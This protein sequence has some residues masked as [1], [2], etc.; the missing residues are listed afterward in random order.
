MTK[1]LIFWICIGY[2][3][4]NFHMASLFNVTKLQRQL[5][6]REVSEMAYGKELIL[7]LYNCD[8]SKFNRESI[9]EWLKELCV[10]INMSRAD[11]H[12]HY[13]DYVGYE[14]GA[15]E[16]MLAPKHLCGTSG[17]QFITTSNITIHTLDKAKE[18]YINIFSCRN[19]S[20]F[21]AARFTQDWFSAAR[22]RDRTIDR[23]EN[24]QCKC[25]TLPETDECY[26]CTHNNRCSGPSRRKINPIENEPCQMFKD[27]VETE[28]E[29][30]EL[31][32]RATNEDLHNDQK[33]VEDV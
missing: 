2:A 32:A 24:S 19:F 13:W 27:A 9:R 12:L 20:S 3:I 29:L 17:V 16:K 5:P 6:N 26:A 10:L 15:E 4:S 31:I 33:K 23:G 25:Y 7:D 8:V 11:L 18:M 22:M 30:D 1:L 21:D 14:E 28:K